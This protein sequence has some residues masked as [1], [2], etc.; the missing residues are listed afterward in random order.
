MTYKCLTQREDTTIHTM[1]LFATTK[2][3][4]KVIT[5]MLAAH[6]KY[7]DQAQVDMVVDSKLSDRPLYLSILANEL[8]V[9][10]TYRLVYSRNSPH[11]SK[12]SFVNNWTF[13]KKKICKF[14]YFSIKQGL[15]PIA[16]G[17]NN[18]K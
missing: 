15:L 5:D 7:L 1:P 2:D 13:K 12:F 14:T 4:S 3:K 10:G 6:C 9:G 16:L 11:F 17:K 8:R 18:L